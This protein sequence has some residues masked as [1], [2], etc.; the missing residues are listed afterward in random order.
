MASCDRRGPLSRS[1]AAQPDRALAER[2]PH[3]FRLDER[4]AADLILFARRFAAHMRYYD[5]TNA[6][7]GDWSGFFEG[8]ISAILASLAKLP[9][10]PFRAALADIERFLEAEP[11]RPEAELRTHFGLIFHLPLTL[12]R[13]LAERQ[14]ALEAD[15]PLYPELQGIGARE[16]GPA[17][18]ELASYH[19][20]AL[21]AGLIDAAPLDPVDF[22]TTANPGGPGP[23]LSDQ[24]ARILFTGEAFEAMTLAPR[25]V[26][27]FAPMGW[28][29][30]Y[31]GAPADGAPY[32][33]AVTTYGQVYDALN[34]N[35]LVSAMERIF[36]AIERARRLAAAR[37]TES[38]EN[39]AA[40]TP[41]YALWL[42]F[43]SMFEKARDELN[44]LTGR[45]LDFYYE[46]VLRLS[47]RGPVA[48]HAHVLVD[49]AKGR[50]A[51]LLAK[52]T[53]LRGGKD[54]LGREVVYTLDEDIVVNRAKVAELSAVTVEEATVGGQPQVIVRAAPVAAS[55]DGL[56]AELPEEAPHF[57]PFGPSDAPFAR[58]GFAV[59]DRQLFMREGARR[60][61]LRFSVPD[62]G[63]DRALPGFRARLTAEEG[64]LDISGPPKLRARIDDGLMTFA[65]N[66][67]GDDPAIVS[68]DP[69]LHG[70]GYPA[71][72]PVLEISV[73]F[74]EG[75]AAARVFARY[76][77]TMRGEPT[78]VTR[79]SG[80]RRM[81]VAT[82]DGVADPAAGF[83]PFGAQPKI[84]STWTIGSAEAFSRKLARLKIGV[85]WAEPHTNATF[86]RRRDSDDYRV[87]FQYLDGGVWTTASAET[88]GLKIAAG[89]ADPRI[90]ARGI[91]AASDAARQTLDDPPFDAKARNGYVRMTLDS[92]F[93]H[94][95]FI[96]KKT[97]RLIEAAKEGGV[98]PTDTGSY[99]YDSANLP[100][101]PYT[102]EVKEIFLDYLSEERPV[103]RTWR[104]HP[105]GIEAAEREGRLFPD[106]PY[107]GA[108]FIGVDA[109]A[110]P[111]R[112]SLL[113]QVA[114]GTGDPLLEAPALSHAYL[115]GEV[116]TPFTDQEV[117]DRT[118]DLSR[119]GVLAYAVPRAASPAIAAMPAGRRW[120]RLAAPQNAA[121]VN[122]ILSIDAQAV[123]ASFLDQKNDPALLETPLPPGAITK[124]KTPDPAV[125]GLRQPYASFGGR[126][127]EDRAA[128]HRRASERLRH[129][130][131]A[132]TIWDYEHLALEA[133]P[134]VYRVKALNHTELKRA[135]GKILG[136]NELSPGA[137]TVVAVPYTD[138]AAQ[139]DPLRP[140]ADRAT[141]AGLSELL[142]RRAS[143]FVRLEV[144]NPRFEEVH[145]ALNVAFRP[146]IEDLDFYRGE[147]EA[148]LIAHLTPWRRQGV[149]GV[150][151]GG[152]I[153][154]STII[155]FVEELPFVDFLEDVR[156]YHRPNP[157]IPAWTRIDAEIVRATT[158]RS[159][160]VS[161]P[162][163]AIGLA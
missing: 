22:T 90:R 66:L 64:W 87:S 23:R 137:V 159:V 98:G 89:A 107:A 16:I 126:G 135:G 155:D 109:L 111:A 25:A 104:L 41:H 57:A 28:P 27:P 110:P 128:Y 15:R 17:L 51:H 42:A 132:V 40:H 3:Y 63:P 67:D 68:A 60:M 157:E 39:F 78:L 130:D 50:E 93:G 83:M 24:V 145:V 131:R 56:G 138:D 4:D 47:R 82:D 148:A 2:D 26:A 32:A 84:G 14:S 9:V 31:A 35:L 86:F 73:D 85:T 123:R 81:S 127:R 113:F 140:Y 163:H 55:A 92:D 160:L 95:E 29:A 20:G 7:A 70:P 77:D 88:A 33:D 133:Y 121:A 129:K 134:S 34:Y 152:L 97:L 62:P 158:A 12:F 10:D 108:L 151:F 147:L 139:F 142:A 18:A 122:R 162:S 119:S 112:L 153:Y 76:R 48:D 125:K 156:L 120:L 1:G 54:G 154:K 117:D 101:D 21:G 5:P 44:D 49:L 45:H 136:D 143:P 106:L 150:E 94:G 100:L 52:G 91:E 61:I 80:L 99:N 36:Q 59:A 115:K 75:Q 53:R 6:A 19:R 144:E 71:D 65:V 146:G 118:A 30:Y 13:D 72:A 58:V 38:L 102:P 46:E 43:L 103:A 116:W 74:D 124:L 141:L 79:G 149:A 69:E 161:A 37:L 105:F 8:D 114:N 11:G 96:D